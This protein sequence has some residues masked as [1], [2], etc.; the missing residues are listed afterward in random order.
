MVYDCKIFTLINNLVSN[1]VFNSGLLLFEYFI[2]LN[3]KYF[4]IVNIIHKY[5]RKQNKFPLNIIMHL[6][7]EA[8][9]YS[10][11]YGSYAHN[12]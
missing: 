4:S 8:Y 9:I 1:Y 10:H 7:P 2:S 3:P 6:Q 12:L 5:V 11:K